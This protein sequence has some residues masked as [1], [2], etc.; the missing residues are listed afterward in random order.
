MSAIYFPLQH[1]KY[2]SL[3]H[4]KTIDS[5]SKVFESA[6]DR[7]RFFKNPPSI[8]MQGHHI[9]V[10]G[11]KLWLTPGSKI[12]VIQKNNQK[13]RII[14]GKA[15]VN[16]RSSIKELQ[17]HA[18]V[19]NLTK[20]SYLDRISSFFIRS[21]SQSSGA[22]SVAPELAT[23][24]VGE[25]LK[26]FAHYGSIGFSV[27]LQGLN[28]AKFLT[29]F[30]AAVPLLSSALRVISCCSAVFQLA[31]GSLSLLF[32]S[33]ELVQG[34]DQYHLARKVHDIHGMVIAKQRIIYGLI[35]IAE[36]VLWMSLG[37]LCIACP[38]AAVALG[39]AS[40]VYTILQYMFRGVFA[41]DSATSLAMSIKLLRCIEQYHSKFDTGILKN[42]HLTL[43]EKQ[44]ATRR[45]IE[46]LLNVTEEEK[47]KISEK[48]RHMPSKIAKRLQ[49]KLAKKRLIA[50]RLGIGENLLTEKN[51]AILMTKIE[52][53]F[54][55]HI[56]YQKFFTYISVVSLG[57]SLAGIP[58]SAINF[59][60][61]F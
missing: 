7:D 10:G 59:S 46:Q 52:K 2:S 44:V 4:K 33:L 20:H 13:K 38:Q 18:S 54:K 48:C 45:F 56:L 19:L 61:H 8:K 1:Y 41:A 51:N 37:A 47:M 43:E 31:E 12:V 28:A 26:Q 5:L 57:S 25:H 42:D 21:T 34:I 16:L 17:E 27:T 15:A 29:P 58:I 49:E 32:G 35:Y 60:K 36:G 23:R 22:I 53:C 9:E 40:L 3:I 11:K 30:F 50:Q 6:C 14:A 24:P 39:V 55:N